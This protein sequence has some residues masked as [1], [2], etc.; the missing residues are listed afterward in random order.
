ML[1]AYFI[2]FTTYG[3]WLHG[4]DPGS[5]DRKHNT[6]ET[7]LLPASERHE[8]KMQQSLRQE[9]YTLDE[10]RREVVLRTLREVARHRG[11]SLHAAHVRHNHIHLLISAEQPPEKVM[12]DLKAWSSRRLREAFNESA[13]RDRWT[14]H[15]STRWLN[16]DAE[17]EQ[18]RRYIVEDQGK[19]MS[20]YD[21]MN[22]ELEA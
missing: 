15:G 4:R 13:D 20:V 16:T 11:W 14:Q 7:P 9:P 17:F 12:S 5:V 2:T 1:P 10:A 19:P 21:A 6:L 18:V 22:H 8:S 3:T